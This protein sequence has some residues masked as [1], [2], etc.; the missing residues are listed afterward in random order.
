V[1]V[2]PHAKQIGEIVS[3]PQGNAMK[4]FAD[5]QALVFVDWRGGAARATPK[6]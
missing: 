3:V 6:R 2:V 1:S 5:V 4:V